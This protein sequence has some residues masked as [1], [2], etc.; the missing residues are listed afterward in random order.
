MNESDKK[1]L[2]EWLGKK[3]FSSPY[4]VIHCAT[5]QCGEFKVIHCATCQCGEF[6]RTFKA[7][8]DFFACFDKLV[9]LGEWQRFEDYADDCHNDALLEDENFFKKYYSLTQWLLSRTESGEYRLCQLV[10]EWLT[11]QEGV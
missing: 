10:A 9:E 6:N 5:C 3:W 11:A 2:T 4:K 7:D 8:K 1:R